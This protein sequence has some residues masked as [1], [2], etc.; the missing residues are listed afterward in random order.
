[1]GGD[2]AEIVRGNPIIEAPVR[3]FRSAAVFLALLAATSAVS[4][5]QSPPRFR[6]S[7]DVIPVDVTVLDNSG[8]PVEGLSASDFNV[9]VDGELRRVVSVDFVSY[10]SARR[11][12]ADAAPP[13]GYVSNEISGD[14]RLIVIAIDQPNILFTA[15]RPIQDAVNAFIDR[16][17]PA[18]RVAVI[19][20]GLSAP[21]ISFTSDFAKAKNAV[22]HMPGQQTG[23]R[24]MGLTTALEI[25]RGEQRAL[26]EIVARDCILAR[27][28]DACIKQIQRE[29]E[30]IA[31]NARRDADRSFG[32][33][34]LLLRGLQT[35]EG[36]KTLVLVSQGFIVDAHERGDGA[37]RLAG[38]EALATAARTSIYSIKLEEAMDD[39]AANRRLLSIADESLGRR[40][41][42]EALAAATRGAIFNV[43]GTGAGVMER[44]TTEL[45]GS[46]LLGVESTPRDR[47]GQSHPI[48]IEVPRAA[49][50]RTHRALLVASPS[51][52]AAEE[53]VRR[54]LTSPVGASALPLRAIVFAVRGVDPSTL[55][56][57]IH[58]DVGSGYTDR[59]RLPAGFTIL[60]KDGRVVGSEITE[61]DLEPASRGLPSALMFNAGASVRPGEYVIR[62]AVAD[63][64]RVGS[65]DVPARASL[66]SAGDGV[67]VT[68][69]FAGGATPPG[70][71]LHPTIGSRVSHSAV[72]GYLEAYG[73]GAGSVA[74]T[75]EIAASETSAALL[76]AS[77]TP[78]SAGVERVLFSQMLPVQRLPPGGYHLR[79]VVTAGGAPVRTLSRAFEIPA[80]AADGMAGT[81]FLPVDVETLTRTFRVSEALAPDTVEAF[82]ER[83][84][85]G[86]REPF[87]RGVSLLRNGNYV[88]A[89]VTFKEAAD[90]G[91]G[92]SAVAYLGVCLA[93]TGHDVEAAQLFRVAI[94]DAGP[95]QVRQ[96]LGESLMRTSNFGEARGVLDAAAKQW[97]TEMRFTRP[98]ALLNAISGRGSDA[99]RLIGDAIRA[100][101]GDAD[102]EFLA[103]EWL[104]RGRRAGVSFGAPGEELRLA[105]SFADLYARANGPN[106]PLVDHWLRYLERR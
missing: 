30:E 79:A 9:R 37:A 17:R 54:A 83:V 29:A 22:A 60:D 64:D 14:G 2:A 5:Q 92:N 15:F 3:N 67:T 76:S 46:Y 70:D 38:L 34:G 6:S 95:P 66:V 18:D 97:P 103:L 42:L 72:H 41:G 10:S 40:R 91:A 71:L 57:L 69:L 47:N 100:D 8:R 33:I 101:P 90:R 24:G 4:S 68:E 80:S 98:L 102:A 62:I 96:W 12:I 44:L 53:Q 85:S 35:I 7:V 93:M 26:R 43:T 61:A 82:R 58:A 52:E 56:L 21:S 94:A 63:G 25:D 106:Q 59:R 19:G 81:L 31:E 87:D 78:R 1:M 55:Q 45:S 49:I 105:R 65:V 74:V 32:S 13:E 75:F 11:T 86:A 39:I 23:D 51:T 16:L 104:F 28:R 20:F 89:G 27:A 88:D 36:P 77:V 84:A 99:F 50:V 73:R 48:A